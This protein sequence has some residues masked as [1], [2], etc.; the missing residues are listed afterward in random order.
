[1]TGFEAQDI[2]KMIEAF[3]YK[4][5]HEARNKAIIEMMADCGLRGMEIRTL[6]FNNVEDTKY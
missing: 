2:Y 4:S 3:S 5:Y 1:M 6:P